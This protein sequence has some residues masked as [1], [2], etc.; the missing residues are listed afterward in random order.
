MR[1]SL[2]VCFRLFAC[3]SHVFNPLQTKFVS[4]NFHSL[5]GMSQVMIGTYLGWVSGAVY[6]IS[7]IPQIWQN[8]QTR[9]VEVI[10]IPLLFVLVM[11]VIH[12]SN[13]V[14]TVLVSLTV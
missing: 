14:L 11:H 3:P 8:F 9:E 6:L 4:N 10:L 1:I 12:G 7:R 5:S 2:L 13:F